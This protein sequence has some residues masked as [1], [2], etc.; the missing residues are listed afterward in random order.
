V[1]M[2]LKTVLWWI[3]SVI[4]KG[5]TLR[6]FLLTPIPNTATGLLFTEPTPIPIISMNPECGSTHVELK[7]VA[8]P[9]I[10]VL[11]C[12]VLE[13]QMSLHKMFGH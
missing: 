3:S 4:I 11:L 2:E 7:D 1:I 10:L 12:L 13:A 8:G 9:K 5:K 6:C